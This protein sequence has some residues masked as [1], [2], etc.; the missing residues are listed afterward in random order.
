MT[1][2]DQANPIG[3]AD[4]FAEA[5]AEGIERAREALKPWDPQRNAV[6]DIIVDIFAELMHLCDAE[7]IDVDETIESARKHHSAEKRPT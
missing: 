3:D 2:Q 7:G 5:R 1:T 6:D 4:E